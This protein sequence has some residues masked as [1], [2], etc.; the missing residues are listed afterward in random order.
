M[1]TLINL[2]GG[3]TIPNLIAQK[4]VEPQKIVLVFSKG[5]VKQKENYKKI[6]PEIDFQEIEIEPYDYDTIANITSQIVNN[7]ATDEIILNFTGGTK[8]MSLASFSVFSNK[9]LLSIYIDSENG[10]IYKYKPGYTEIDD[11]NIKI[12]L[13][14][15]LK[16]NG[17]IYQISD[18]KKVNDSRKKY[19]EY[20]ENNYNIEISRF[21]DTINKSFE[22]N[23]QQFYKSQFP[24]VSGK[25]KYSWDNLRNVSIIELNG[26][27]FA[28]EGKDSI[29]YLTGLWFEDLVF[30]KKFYGT[31]YYDEILRNIHL[32]DKRGKQDMIELDIVGLFKNNFHLFEL[33][34]GKP[35]KEALNNL[36]TIKEQLGTYT[37]LFLI[38]YFGIEEN[39]TIVERMQDLQITYYKYSDFVLENCFESININL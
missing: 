17:H 28:I 36:T 4:F 30:Y 24:I 5:S 8:I 3:Q 22:A 29:K 20:L 16:L 26:H 15:Y 39:S 27:E 7:N 11:I 2:I 13:E 25:L 32:Q 34:S 23:K 37:K 19:Y 1:K 6:S 9:K 14:E 21:L 35:R 38:S 18:E 33:K 12:T 31:I 10:K